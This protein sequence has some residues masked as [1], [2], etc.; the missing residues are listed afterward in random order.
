MS[1]TALEACNATNSSIFPLTAVNICSVK[2][3][4]GCCRGRGGG[5]GGVQ[6]VYGSVAGGKMSPLP[7]YLYKELGPTGLED[8]GA[9]KAGG[10]EGTEVGGVLPDEVVPSAA[11]ILASTLDIRES[12]EADTA[13]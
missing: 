9:E 2:R 1:P 12:N 13:V 5:G 6:L 7:T 10:R 11:L 8:I 3:Y 4:P